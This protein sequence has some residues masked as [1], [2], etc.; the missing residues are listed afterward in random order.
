MKYTVNYSVK[1]I[2]YFTSL[3]HPVDECCLVKLPRAADPLPNR[4]CGLTA[5]TQK[6]HDSMPGAL[7]LIHASFHARCINSNTPGM[8]SCKMY[9]IVI[10][11]PCKD[12]K[13][14]GNHDIMI[15][16]SN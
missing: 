1:W 7:V 2:H 8:M 13:N 6:F 5:N 3:N 10:N 16:S 15:P 12:K 14:S 9:Y 4:A 11:S